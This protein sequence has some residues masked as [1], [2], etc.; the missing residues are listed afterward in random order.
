MVRASRSGVES[1]LVGWSVL[2]HRRSDL[3]GDVC[4]NS[5]MESQKWNLRGGIDD[6]I[7]PKGLTKVSVR[8][9]AVLI[10]K[11]T[12]KA[13]SN[14]SQLGTATSLDRVSALFI[15]TYYHPRTDR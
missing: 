12:E 9:K 10:L 4:L 6:S 1:Y 14:A 15:L 3:V 8:L 11:A 13:D 7:D 5:F 2:F